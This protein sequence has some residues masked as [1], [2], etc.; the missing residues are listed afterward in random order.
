[1]TASTINRAWHQ[2]RRI[3]TNATFSE[4]LS[5]HLEHAKQC[6]CRPIPAATLDE[7]QRRGWNLPAQATGETWARD[8]RTG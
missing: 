7:L 2:A 4:R 3:P 1:M 8:D 5:W 6:G